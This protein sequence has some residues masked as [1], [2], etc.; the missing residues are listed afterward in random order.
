LGK[1]KSATMIHAISEDP[2]K[3]KIDQLYPLAMK[4]GDP[5]EMSA[6]PMKGRGRCIRRKLISRSGILFTIH[7]AD[8]S[9]KEW[10]WFD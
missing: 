1:E 10:K 3:E 7:F 5:F 8:G 2:D 6:G 4:V 9:I